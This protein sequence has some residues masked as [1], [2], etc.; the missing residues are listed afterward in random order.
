MGLS[1]GLSGKVKLSF[2]IGSRIDISTEIKPRRC[3][4]KFKNVRYV[5]CHRN[6]GQVW[7][8]NL[9]GKYHLSRL[10]FSESKFIFI[11]LLMSSV[12]VSTVGSLVL[13]CA[14]SSLMTS[15]LVVKIF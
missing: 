7:I 12:G 4:Y 2:F 15:V 14:P 8:R 13:V 1:G 5:T 6:S 10:L 11:G 9:T 3:K